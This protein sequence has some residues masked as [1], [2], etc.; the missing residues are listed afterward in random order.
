[1]YHRIGGHSLHVPPLWS[2]LQTDGSFIPHQR[3][4]R[5]AFLLHSDDTTYRKMFAIKAKDSTE[6]EWAARNFIALR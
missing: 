5:V 6:T 1:M 3:L 4:A 2:K